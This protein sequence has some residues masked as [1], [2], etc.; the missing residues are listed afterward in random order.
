MRRREFI[1]LLGGA[2]T[3]WPL[4]VRAQQPERVR[5]IGVLMNLAADDPEGLSPYR[6]AASYVDRILKGEKPEYIIQGGINATLINVA[7]DR[8][9][10]S[11]D[12]IPPVFPYDLDAVDRNSLPSVTRR[13]E[14][15]VG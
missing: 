15:E 5:R 7:P 4:A 1:S 8:A 10:G 6:R 3:T 14:G 12:P 2:A 11:Y 13:N 9:A